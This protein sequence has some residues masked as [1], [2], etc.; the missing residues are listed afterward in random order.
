MSDR[1]VEHPHDASG[2]IGRDHGGMAP[3]RVGYAGIVEPSMRIET[4]RHVNPCRPRQAAEALQSYWLIRP[5][6][7]DQKT[8]LPDD[9]L[10]RDA[11]QF[12][13]QRTRLRHECGCG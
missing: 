4:L 10:Y 9:V 13:E 3:A 11:A 8:L 1:V 7:L 5:G 6:P 12:S 2:D